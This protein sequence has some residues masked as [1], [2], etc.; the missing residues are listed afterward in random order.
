[1]VYKCKGADCLKKGKCYRFIQDD[2]IHFSWI[3]PVDIENCGFY[4]PYTDIKKAVII[5]KK[6]AQKIEA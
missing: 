4:F 1:M 3:A 6:L 5:S 2:G